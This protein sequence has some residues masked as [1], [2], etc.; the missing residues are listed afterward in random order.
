TASIPIDTAPRALDF[1][2]GQKVYFTALKVDA[3]EVFDPSAGQI[4]S[5]IETGASPHAVR[6][7]PGT[8]IEL[9]V[10][11]TANDLE[12]LDPSANEV[13]GRVEMGK[14]PHGIALT[15]DGKQAYVTNEDSNDVS[16][17][18][19]ATATVKTTIPVGN[20]PRKIAL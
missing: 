5:R 8:A 18:D 4:T 11:Q 20:A 19:L 6:A 14:K 1:G 12:I 3:V 10:S 7:V 17:V 16:L 9:T 15:A 2:P 13:A